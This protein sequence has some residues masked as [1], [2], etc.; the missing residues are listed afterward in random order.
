MTQQNLQQDTWK[1]MAGVAA[2][3]LIEDGMVIGLGSGSTAVHLI[4]ALAERIQNGLRIV[5]AVPSSK[6]TEDL[7]GNLGIPLTTLDAHPLLDLD[8]DGADE[9]DSQ[10]NLIKGGGG[11]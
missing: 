8:I 10:L 1:K 4:Y 5:G 6:A 11:A 9:I 7:A 2:A 3:Q